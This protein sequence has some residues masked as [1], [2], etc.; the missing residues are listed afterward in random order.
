VTGALKSIVVL[1]ALLFGMAIAVVSVLPL[2]RVALGTRPHYA[3]RAAAIHQAAIL[4]LAAHI[5][6]F[7]AASAVAWFAAD[8][9]AK[10]VTGKMLAFVA[11]LALGF[12]TEWLQHAIYRNP[13]ESSDV[14]INTLASAAAFAVLALITRWRSARLSLRSPI[15]DEC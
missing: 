14:W 12:T 6:I 7:A 8:F 5:L 3:A 10:G 11:T 15:Q 4:H 13:I 9:A 2:N 1:L